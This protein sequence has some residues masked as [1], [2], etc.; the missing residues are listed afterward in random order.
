M[1]VASISIPAPA[2]GATSTDGGKVYGWVISIPAP[3]RGATA[4]GFVTAVQKFISI[5]APARGATRQFARFMEES[6]I[7]IP[8][9]ARGATPG[10]THA[11]YGRIYFNSRPC[12]RGDTPSYLAADG[13]IKFQFPPLREGRP[14]RLL[15]EQTQSSISIPAP[16]RGATPI[17]CP[18][19]FRI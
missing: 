4:F 11:L 10:R 7:S 1:Y 9:P 2:R 6:R 19:S 3:A 14:A 12:E 13:T 8:A 17:F 18:I 5:P 16:A 15:A